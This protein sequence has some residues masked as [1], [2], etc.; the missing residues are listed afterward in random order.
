MGDVDQSALERSDRHTYCPFKGTASYYHVRAGAD[1]IENAIWTYE[2][3][4]PA[5]RQIAGHVACYPSKLEVQ[6][7]AAHGR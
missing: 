6:V 4:Y 1:L 7:R 2:Q 5:V 3:P